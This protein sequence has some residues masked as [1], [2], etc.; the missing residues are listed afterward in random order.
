MCVCVCPRV[1][2]CVLSESGMGATTEEGGV[3][4][5][6]AR[7]DEGQKSEITGKRSASVCVRV[8]VG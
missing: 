5:R 2:V 8:C 1:R 7:I 3:F 6:E 4:E